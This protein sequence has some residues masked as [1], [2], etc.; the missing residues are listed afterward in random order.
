MTILEKLKS[1]RLYFDGGYGTI[2]QERGL[3]PGESP[4][5]WNLS[6]PDEIVKLHLEYLRSGSDIITTNTFGANSIKF[7]ENKGTPSLEKIIGAAI[8]NAKK[9]RSIFGKEDKYIAL[10][11]GP[12]GK[13]LKPLGELDFEDAVKIFAETVRL[14]KAFGADLIIIETMNDSYETKASVLAAKE[15]SDLPIFVTNAYDEGGKLLTGASPEAMVAL[16]EGMRV[17]A[18]GLNCGFGPDK[19]LPIAERILKCTSLPVIV[20]P[21]AGIP[22][23]KNG[24]TEFETDS[25]TFAYFMEKIALLG[26][27]L[28]GGC[29][30]TT[31]SHIK[32]MREK[33]EKI[34]YIKPDEKNFTLV[35]SYTKAVFFDKEPLLIGERINPT[36]KKLFKAELL[37]NKYD[38][39]VKESVSQEEE[40]AHIL[41]VNVGLP[42]ICEAEVLENAVKLIQSVTDLPLQIDTSSPEAMERALRIYNGKAMINSVS[43]KKEVMDAVFPLASKYGGVVVALT[44]DENGIPKTA[45][46]RIAIA[47]KIILEAQ[48]YGIKKK[49][50]IVDPLA[51][52]IS[53]D[54]E[55]ALVTLECIEKLSEIGISTSLGVSN[56][57]FGLPEREIITSSF[58]TM[59]MEK[60][61]KAAIMNPHSND[62]KKAY[63][64]YLAL[65]GLDDN[66]EKY[67]AF[68]SK[69]VKKE[70][71]ND[72]T[73]KNE[74]PVES[75]KKAIIKG[76]SSEAKKYTEML[77]DKM[78]SMEIIN[79]AIVPALDEVGVSFEN[80]KTFLPQ[81]LMSAEASK[82]SFDVI[83]KYMASLGKQRQKKMKIA[84]ATVKGDIHDIGKNIVKALLENY[85]FEVLDLGKD[86]EPEE[87]LSAVKKDNIRLLGLSALMTT[88]V[89]SMEETIRIVKK[90]VPSC[91]IMVGG[92]V[93][94]KDYAEKIGAD[95]YAKDAM[96]AVRY[97]ETINE[98]F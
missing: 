19:M 87:I 28:L 80:K 9:A 13:L 46:G 64:A 81:L 62:M 83:K 68:A 39:I 7:S 58:F 79:E 55:S 52:T 65:S 89:S 45:K 70:Q 38:Y 16:L 48:K 49:D 26:A 93:M 88:T 57:S 47:E 56:V 63:Y 50:I 73:D 54:K 3:L 86:V 1:G 69:E 20:N 2:L 8:E 17:D 15:E 31:P 41:D 32:A 42:G 67:I 34:P 5:L 4:E 98:E 61:L 96:E 66:F 92:A 77:L 78:E 29:C 21:N 51:M 6:H 40:G 37:E 10:D 75:L 22:C 24:K 23:F 44:I 11:I 12:T 72:N 84:I 18:I 36:G 60:G 14:G 53:T 94:T 30:G 91:R 71:E 85:D 95:S 27:N 33:C 35:S 97:A 59:A 25:D 90:E 76:I 74:T 82:D 43:G